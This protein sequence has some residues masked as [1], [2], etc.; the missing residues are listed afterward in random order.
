MR[1]SPQY[2]CAPR[3]Y[4]KFLL[5]CLVCLAQVYGVGG[6]D[7]RRMADFRHASRAEI[8][9]WVAEEKLFSGLLGTAEL[10]RTLGRGLAC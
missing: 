2:P 5:T 7:L 3:Y 1:R 8:E 6:G 4:K 9:C 10:A